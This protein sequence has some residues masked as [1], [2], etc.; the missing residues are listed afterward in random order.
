[1]LE[2]KQHN[3]IPK[4]INHNIIHIKIIDHKTAN[5]IKQAIRVEVNVNFHKASQPRFC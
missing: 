2:Q 4:N 5:K 1:M 3:K